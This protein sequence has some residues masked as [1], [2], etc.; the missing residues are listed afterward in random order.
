MAKSH[1]WVNFGS[2]DYLETSMSTASPL[3][4]LA[5]A[6]RDIADTLL[7]FVYWTRLVASVSS[8]S[9]PPW[10]WLHAATVDWLS[11][12][13]TESDSHAVNFTDN[14]PHQMGWSRDAVSVYQTSTAG[15]YQVIFQGPA[16][17]I[18]LE[19]SRKGYSVSNLPSLSVQR[20][21]TD[22]NGVFDNFASYGVTFTSLLTGRAL[23]SSDLPAPP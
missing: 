17:G 13:D 9:P 20:W 3:V 23:W 16:E 5:T 18:N 14:D 8:T 7:R 4:T 21:L 15:R 12:F 22:D 10:Y 19:G 6:T 1:Y 11:F 2:S